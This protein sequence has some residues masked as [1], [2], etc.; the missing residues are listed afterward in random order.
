MASGFDRKL[1][2]PGR[3][4]LESVG[5]RL[6]SAEFEAAFSVLDTNRDRALDYSE[7]VDAVQRYGTASPGK[8]ERSSTENNPQMLDAFNRGLWAA[9]QGNRPAAAPAHVLEA[10]DRLAL[11]CENK[12][13]G[14]SLARW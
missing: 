12:V 11:E 1:L 9:E 10:V 5:V 7:L 14:C 2:T 3:R 13:C 6:S 4:A 8:A